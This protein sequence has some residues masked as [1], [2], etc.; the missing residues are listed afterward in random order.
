MQQYGGWMKACRRSRRESR[1]CFDQIP[2]K[3]ELVGCICNAVT[4]PWLCLAAACDDDYYTYVR[5]GRL[6]SL[7]AHF[8][9]NSTRET[10]TDD[11]RERETN[12]CFKSAEEEDNTLRASFLAATSEPH[13]RRLI[14]Q[15]KLVAILL[16]LLFP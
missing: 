4:A 10:Q 1:D 16:C 5:R 7:I 11:E 15:T 6:L 3:V 9:F 14:E 8:S 2:S 13:S 12:C